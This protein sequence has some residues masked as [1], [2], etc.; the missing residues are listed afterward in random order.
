MMIHPLHIAGN[1]PIKTFFI[2]TM[3]L[4]QKVPYWKYLCSRH[5]CMVSP[6]SLENNQAVVMWELEMMKNS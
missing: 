3:S 5:R 2:N 1:L 6:T 4:S